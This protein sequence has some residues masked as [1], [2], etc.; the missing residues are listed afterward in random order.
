MKPPAA[1]GRPG[2]QPTQP[3]KYDGVG[4]RSLHLDWRKPAQ[5]ISELKG[6][7]SIMNESSLGRPQE[8]LED[9]HYDKEFFQC[10][11]SQN[12]AL[13]H[14]PLPQYRQ[15]FIQLFSRRIVLTT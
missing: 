8:L 9:K 7:R 6:S 4:E 11:V 10:W 15:L 3:R 13:H 5:G 2:T 12:E 1:R 14:S